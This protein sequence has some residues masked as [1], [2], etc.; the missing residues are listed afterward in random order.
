[1]IKQVIV[2]LL[3]PDA[4]DDSSI[5]KS[6]AAECAV[7]TGRITGY[8]IR[9]KS[10]DARSRQARVILQAEVFIDEQPK[11]SPAFDPGLRDVT[12]ASHAVIVGAGPAGLFAAL[13]LISL[14]VKPIIIERGK[15]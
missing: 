3:P 14:G 13:R 1:M 2:S 7:N 10:I 4:A 12:H 8:T 6:I 5:K 15:D 9:K 11:D